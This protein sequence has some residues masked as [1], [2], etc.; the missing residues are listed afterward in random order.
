LVIVNRDITERKR[1]EERLEHNLF[2]DP[3]TGLPNRRQFL[4]RLENSFVRS[5]REVGRPYSLMLANVDHFKVFNETMGTGAG[6]H[7]LMEIGRRVSTY[8]R[9]QDTMARIGSVGATAD[10]V[11]FRLG[12]DEF[13]ILLDAVD[14]PS[15]AMRWAKGIQ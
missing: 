2:H 11:L 3:L 14:D 13:A 9:Q 12:G 6:D 1:A 10:F 4:E 7:V 8:L 15:D 5:R